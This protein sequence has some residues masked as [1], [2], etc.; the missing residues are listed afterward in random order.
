MES[1]YFHMF[2]CIFFLLIFILFFPNQRLL[3]QKEPNYLYITEIN[4]YIEEDILREKINNDVKSPL[5]VFLLEV[6]LPFNASV[7]LIQDTNDKVKNVSQQIAL[8]GN[9]NVQ[10]TGIIDRS[11]ADY[12]IKL[13][14][15]K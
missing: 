10:V 2:K 6:H 11:I 4:R 1:K 13:Y 14:L 9:N 12:Y 3:A 8:L 7:V 5:E 15:R